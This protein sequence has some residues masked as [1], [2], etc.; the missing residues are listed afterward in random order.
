MSGFFWVQCF[1]CKAAL[2]K[3]LISGEL[4]ILC[5]II[6]GQ[7]HTEQQKYIK[8]GHG[9]NQAC[10]GSVI[11]M[12]FFSRWALPMILV[13]SGRTLPCLVIFLPMQARHVTSSVLKLR[14]L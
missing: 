4:Q 2:T 3:Y 11:S 6:M 14:K 9:T 8:K 5:V 13:Q 7:K 10:L 12:V 1:R